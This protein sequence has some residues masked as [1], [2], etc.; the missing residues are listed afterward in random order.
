M[1][2]LRHWRKPTQITQLLGDSLDA[3][4]CSLAPH[5]L[6]HMAWSL[7]EAD[8]ADVTKTKQKADFTSKKA[9]DLTG[10]PKVLK[11]SLWR[12]KTLQAAFSLRWCLKGIVQELLDGTKIKPKGYGNT[13]MEDPAGSQRKEQV[14]SRPCLLQIQPHPELPQA[15]QRQL[16]PYRV[17]WSLQVMDARHH[18]LHR[19]KC[20]LEY[21]LSLEYMLLLL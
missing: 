9:I 18:I 10:P 3:R 11:W 6:K 13:G 19:R 7:K 15:F 1:R 21:D 2:K 20:I 17:L 14:T 12:E 16:G 4:P 5:G 8:L